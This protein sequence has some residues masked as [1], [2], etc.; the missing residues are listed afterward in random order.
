MTEEHGFFDRDGLLVEYYDAAMIEV[1][2]V[3]FYRG[4]AEETGGP[5]LELACGTGRVLWPLAEAGFEMVGLDR[6][7]PMLRCAEAKRR[8]GPGSVRLVHGDMRE[9]DL[10]E[11]FGLIFCAVRSF[12][13]LLTPE[14]Q[15]EALRCAHRHLRPGARLAINIFDPKLEWCLD[16]EIDPPDLHVHG[17]HR[18]PETANSVRIDTVSRINDASRQI[19]TERWRLTETDPDGTV[20]REEEGVLRLRWTYRWEMRYLLERCGFEVE[21][22]YSD[23]ERSPP[24][25]GKEQ[26]WVAR[27]A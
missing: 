24:A 21:A 17:P 22:E 2:D 12:Q 1:G 14:N 27:R 3:G 20:L 6:S 5:V 15:H 23:Y 10:E 8:D 26:I 19:L 25:Y 13:S 7:E 18:H 16:G 4:L 11:R 9:F